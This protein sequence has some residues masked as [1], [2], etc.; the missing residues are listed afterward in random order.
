MDRALENALQAGFP[1]HIQSCLPV[2]LHPVS[3]MFLR[4][5]LDGN[6]TTAEFLRFFHMPN[7]DYLSVAQCLLRAVLQFG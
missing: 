1:N 7:S 5:W 4:H 2:D 3:A 6:L